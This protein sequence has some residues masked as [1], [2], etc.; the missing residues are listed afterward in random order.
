MYLYNG[1]CKCILVVFFPTKNKIFFPE[2]SSRKSKVKALDC[3]CYVHTIMYV[4]ER[5]KRSFVNDDGNFMVTFSSGVSREA[6]CLSLCFF[7]KVDMGGI[8]ERS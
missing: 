6:N 7:G 8:Y 5:E 1:A 4:M 2:M 3:V